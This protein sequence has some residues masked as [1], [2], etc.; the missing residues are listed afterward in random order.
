MKTYIAFFRGINVG[1]KNRL[2]MKDLVVAMQD[3]G[4][5]RVRTYIQSG[6]AF[7]SGA[8]GEAV[9]A[10][11]LIEERHGFKPGVCV[12]GVEELRR[13]LSENPFPEAEGKACHFN[14]CE[15]IP[16]AVDEQRLE[17]LRKESERYALQGKV[18]Y[19]YAPEG[20]GRS[21]LAAQAE[22]CLGVTTTG[23][24]LNTVMKTLALA[25]G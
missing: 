19:F 17:L 10:A 25:E 5:S 23:R 21:K 16:D 13:A 12:L 3:A 11:A 22:R 24:N 18:F 8:P 7:Y 14:F 4:A 20:I 15:R 2:P 9:K 6:N 1:G